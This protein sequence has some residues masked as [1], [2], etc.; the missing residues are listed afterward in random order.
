MSLNQDNLDRAAIRARDTLFDLCA[1]KV[2]MK[3]MHTRS[4]QSMIWD[5]EAIQ[6]AIRSEVNDRLGGASGGMDL[7]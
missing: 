6:T 1:V 7:G 5:L 4:L 3:T 2:D